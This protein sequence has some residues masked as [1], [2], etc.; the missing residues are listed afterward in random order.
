MFVD[1]DVSG[2]VAAVTQRNFYS[3]VNLEGNESLLPRGALTTFIYGDVR[4]IFLG[5]KSS[6]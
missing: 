3:E 2:C 1:V 5:L 4:A 6:L